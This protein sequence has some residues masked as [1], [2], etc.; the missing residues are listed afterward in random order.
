MELITKHCEELATQL[1]PLVLGCLGLTF[2]V[3][4]LFVWLGGLGFRKILAAVAGAVSG[5]ICGFFVID[6][7]PAWTILL[8]AAGAVIAM[9]FEKVFLTILSVVLAVVIGFAILAAPYIENVDSLKEAILQ[10]PIHSWVILSILVL[11]VIITG[12]FLWRLL[13][14]LCCAALGTL[15]IFSGMVFLLQYKG[16]TVADGVL[17]KQIFFAGVFGAMIAFGTVEQLI[18]CRRAGK[19]P[20]AEDQMSR[21]ND[22]NSKK[23]ATWRNK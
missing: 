2:L 9:V 4:G 20:A 5:G 8:S 14:A 11:A 12:S 6:K 13:S 7:N 16:A 10:M 23:R 21:S 18:L 3:S 1:N 17:G 22:Q 15:L 19:H